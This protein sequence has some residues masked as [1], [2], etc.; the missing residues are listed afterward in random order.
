M[1]NDNI[2]KLVWAGLFTALTTVATMVIQIPTPLGGYVNA[3]DT[4]VILGAFFLGPIWGALAAGLGSALADLM[5]PYAIYAPA[6]LIIKA[7]MALTAGSILRS[8][9]KKNAL[10]MAISGSIAAE[11]IMVAGYFAYESTI[12]SYGLGALANIPANGVQAV[13]GAVAGTAL[14]YGL[15]RIPYVKKTF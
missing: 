2:R 5:S 6:T 10:P 3:G 4:V 1:R 15:M 8:S 14:F 11:L 9:K 7:L 13:F 12:L